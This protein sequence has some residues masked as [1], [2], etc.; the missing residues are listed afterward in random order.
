MKRHRFFFLWCLSI[1]SY[2]GAEMGKGGGCRFLRRR[3]RGKGF[4]HSPLFRGALS[5]LKIH[6][7]SSDDSYHSFLHPLQCCCLSLCPFFA[8]F[9]P[10]FTFLALPEKRKRRAK[11]N[12]LACQRKD[13]GRQL[14]VGRSVR[15]ATL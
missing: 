1:P 15:H 9:F 10:S 5:S 2:E 6:K 7:P 3:K 14:G 11:I 4:F 13:S 12:V 8:P